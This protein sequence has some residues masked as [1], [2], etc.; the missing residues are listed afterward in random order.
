MNTTLNKETIVQLYIT[1]KRS[2]RECAKILGISQPW[3]REYMQ[4]Y[5]IEARRPGEYDGSNK[6]KTFTKEHKDNI[7]QSM[8]GNQSWK[9]DVTNKHFNYQRKE[10]L[11]A[12]CQSKILK[13]KCHIDSF[14]NHFCNQECH[15]KWK[16][17][18]LIGKDNPRYNRIPMPCGY[19]NNEVLCTPSRIKRLKRKLV[20]CTPLCHDLWRQENING[21]KLY[22]WKGGY[23][24]Y[25][26]PT[27]MNAKRKA[28]IRDNNTCQR[29]SI[30][31]EQLGKNMDVHHKIPFR[32]FGIE[33]HIEANALSNLIS[34]CCS[35]HKIV[36][37]QNNKNS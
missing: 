23:D 19:C 29:C 1:D 28:R 9:N 8:I 24:P 27:W 3:F 21:D 4:R 31:K 13:K 17:L 34:Y 15:G 12:L 35:C 25:Y 30:T 6:G 32:L 16:S 11:C 37:E 2:T 26:G 20:F 22:N 7:S 36:E 33:R 18:N 14:D 10:V 5:G